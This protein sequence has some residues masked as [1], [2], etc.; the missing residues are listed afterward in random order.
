LANRNHH[1]M[2]VFDG[3]WNISPKCCTI[4]KK[5]GLYLIADT[6]NFDIHYLQWG[7]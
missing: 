3:M 7:C 2:N 6:E 5:R 4:E 1:T